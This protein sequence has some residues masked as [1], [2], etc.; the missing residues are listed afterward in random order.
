[1]KTHIVGKGGHTPLFLRFSL[2]IQDIPTF[3]RSIKKAKVLNNSCNQFVY[4]FYRQSILI[5]EEYLQKWWDA[6]LI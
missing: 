4:N 5:L 3:H 6:N 1:M 2:E